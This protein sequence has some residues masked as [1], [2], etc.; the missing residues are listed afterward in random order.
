M[1]KRG[2][3]MKPNLKTSLLNLQLLE[4]TQLQVNLKNHHLEAAKETCGSQALI[5]H[6]R[7]KS[8]LLEKEFRNK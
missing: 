8:S 1:Q 2:R 3:D 5:T 6:K 7:K 4:L